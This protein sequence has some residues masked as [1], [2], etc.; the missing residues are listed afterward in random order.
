VFAVVLLSLLFVYGH[1]GVAAWGRLMAGQQ[2]SGGAASKGLQWLAWSA[3]WNPNDGQ[4]DLMRAACYRQLEQPQ[5]WAA[6]V[7]RAKRKAAPRSAIEHEVQLHLIQSGNFPSQAETQLAELIAAS[8]SADDVILSFLRGYLATDDQAKAGVL[9]DGWDPEALSPG[10]HTYLRAV[11]QRHLGQVD[12][13]RQNLRAVLR[14]AP[15]NELARAE[16]ADLCTRLGHI[17]PALSEYQRFVASAPANEGAV[18]GFARTLRKRG[19]FEDARRILKQF[20]SAAERSDAMHLEAARLAWAAGDYEEALAAIRPLDL[21]QTEA[22]ETLKFAAMVFFSAGQAS[23]AHSAFSRVYAYDRDQAERYQVGTRGLPFAGSSSE[24]GDWPPQASPSTG[25]DAPAAELADD[26]EDAVAVQ[27]YAEHCSACHGEDGRGNGPAARHL[28][29]RVRDLCDE[30]SQLV[31]TRNGVPT[32]ADTKEVIRRGISGAS[33]PAFDLSDRELNLLV[34]EVMRFRRAGL[35]RAFIAR[36]SAW[37]DEPLEDEIEEFV[38]LHTTPGAVVAVPRLSPTSAATIARGRQIYEQ[39]GCKSCH[40]DDG[41]GVPGLVL[42]DDQ[43]RTTRVRDLA[44]EPL[45]GGR[46]PQSV[47]LRIAVGMPGTPHPSS[48]LSP[49]DLTALV[50]YC[51]ALA[52]ESERQLT[53]FQRFQLADGDAYLSDLEAWRSSL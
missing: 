51:L 15:H 4:I 2:L 52:R 30:K 12:D 6:A 21:A 42:F 27:L 50:A 1:L 35:R 46:E 23:D 13:A 53:N 3:R 26:A 44:H 14:V 49:P 7:E 11:Y 32:F 24:G 18:L 20:P 34:E 28:V 5:L 41:V 43:G 37:G 33:M 8:R 29:P 31:S 22:R 36:L 45:K 39:Q 16:F 38:D 9:L 40:G 48:E 17:E 10:F 25:F 47:Y 19:R